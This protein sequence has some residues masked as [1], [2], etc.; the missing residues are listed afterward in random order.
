MAFILALGKATLVRK[1]NSTSRK[2]LEQPTLEG[3]EVARWLQ[4]IAGDI[5]LALIGD[6]VFIW[7]DEQALEK[8]GRTAAQHYE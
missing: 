6:R 1:Y 2:A 7:E 8:H 4:D 3:Q 5:M